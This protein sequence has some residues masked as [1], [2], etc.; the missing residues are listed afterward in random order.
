MSEP[1]RV[2]GHLEGDDVAAA[3][4]GAGHALGN[5][6]GMVRDE[7]LVCLRVLLL[8]VV[9]DGVV[10]RPDVP[11]GVGRTRGWV[12][13]ASPSGGSTTVIGQALR[14]EL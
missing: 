1:G 8:I 11:L 7:A 5:D 2:L 14:V 12:A 3:V 10:L 13:T 4:G 9:R 6:L